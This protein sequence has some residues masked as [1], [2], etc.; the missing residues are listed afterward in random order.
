MGPG[1]NVVGGAVA[2]T[3]PAST[4]GSAATTWPNP[5]GSVTTGG[6]ASAPVP[7]VVAAGPTAQ[8][9][10][11]VPLGLDRSDASSV[12][13]DVTTVRPLTAAQRPYTGDMGARGPPLVRPAQPGD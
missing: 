2:T 4:T 7:N 5:A 13:D 1:A 3:P 11:Q 9:N 12:A 10:S 8:G 6:L